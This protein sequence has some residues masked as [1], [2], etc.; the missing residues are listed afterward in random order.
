MAV[1]L[2]ET[3]FEDIADENKMIYQAFRSNLRQTLYTLEESHLFI[4]YPC[5]FAPVERREWG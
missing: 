1:T 2:F 3:L 5:E 4:Q